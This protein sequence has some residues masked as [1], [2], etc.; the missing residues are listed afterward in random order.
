[1]KTSDVIDQ[2]IADAQ[3]AHR[4]KQR[5]IYSLSQVR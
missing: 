1:M 4:E 2:L 3:A 5:T